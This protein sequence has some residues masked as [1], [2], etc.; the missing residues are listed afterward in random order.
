VFPR[1]IRLVSLLALLV[2]GNSYYGSERRGGTR[3]SQTPGFLAMSKG[4]KERLFLFIRFA[5]RQK[6]R[7]K[8]IM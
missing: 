1:D 3:G 6:Q 2:E 7:E 4:T 8:N 5:Q